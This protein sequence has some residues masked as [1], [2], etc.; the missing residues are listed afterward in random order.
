MKKL[1][2]IASFFAIGVTFNLKAQFIEDALRYSQNNGSYTIR[3]GGLGTAF[4]GISDDIGALEFNPGGLGLATKSEF[5]LGLGFTRNNTESSFMGQNLSFG[6]KNAYFN[7]IGLVTPFMVGDRNAAFAI[8]Y[9]L[10]SNLDNNI[11]LKGINANSSFVGWTAKNGPTGNAYLDNWTYHL[12]LA[13][14]NGNN[15]LNTPVIGGNE[16]INFIQERGGLHSITGGFSI[17]ISKYLA[18]GFTISGKWGRYKYN[19]TFEEKDQGLN[20]TSKDSIYFVNDTTSPPS[21]VCDFNSLTYESNLE[22]TIGGISGSIGLMAKLN[23]HFRFGLAVKFPT[24]Y[25][26]DEV[27]SEKASA[28]FDAPRSNFDNGISPNPWTPGEYTNSYGIVTPF[29]YSTGLSFNAYNLS[30]AAGLEYSDATQLEFV[31]APEG[32][33]AVNTDIVKYLVGQVSWGIGVEYDI[34]FIP[35]AVRGS[36][37]STSS[38]YQDNIPGADMQKFAFGIGFY[39]APNVR[40][41]GLAQFSKISQLRQNYGVDVSKYTFT[42]NPLNFGIQLTYRY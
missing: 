14:K 5:T 8:G 17:D 38:P 28:T 34:P 42:N 16:Q 37:S 13:G 21:E 33:K 10:E 23:Q 26:V 29:V 3:A 9:F 12:W 25:N 2:L 31:N 35:F 30:I 32:L 40:I 18:A 19:S 15:T 36:Y 6:S 7:N 24:Y 27:F 4:H 22:Q 1:V 41:E 11:S 39:A 20:Y